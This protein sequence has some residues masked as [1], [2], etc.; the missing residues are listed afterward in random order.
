[1]GYE[2]HLWSPFE[3][4]CSS[5]CLSGSM[6][7][8][9]C[10]SLYVHLRYVLAIKANGMWF[11]A[12]HVDAGHE[13]SAPLDSK[14][15]SYMSIAVYQLTSSSYIDSTWTGT[16]PLEINPLSGR[17]ICLSFQTLGR[18]RV[19]FDYCNCINFQCVGPSLRCIYMETGVQWSLYICT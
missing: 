11:C 18:L 16:N 3:L 19:F 1:M 7:V 6:S 4:I 5:F 8:C 12:V 13:V 2:G 14:Y 15:K 9:L 10:V 17:I